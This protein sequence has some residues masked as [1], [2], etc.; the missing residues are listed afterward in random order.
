MPR[1][2]PLIGTGVVV[3]NTTVL[4][5]RHEAGRRFG[6][7]GVVRVIGGDCVNTGI[8]VAGETKDRSG[9]AFSGGSR[10][11]YNRWAATEWSAGWPASQCGDRRLRNGTSSRST[12]LELRFGEAGLKVRWN[13]MAS[14]SL[15]RRTGH[16]RILRSATRSFSAPFQSLLFGPGNL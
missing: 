12:G 2:D 3:E 10:W 5:S 9:G 11:C 8:S 16:A 1:A 13:S 6:E 4:A 15:G 7:N 14:A